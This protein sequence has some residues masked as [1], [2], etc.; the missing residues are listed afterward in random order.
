MVDL[1]VLKRDVDLLK[2]KAT[3]IGTLYGMKAAETLYNTADMYRNDIGKL[4]RKL[5][6]KGKDLQVGESQT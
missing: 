1:E 2:Q 5:T 4:E 6:D 3:Q